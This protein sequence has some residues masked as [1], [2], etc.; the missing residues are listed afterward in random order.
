MV[1][2]EEFW[3][4]CEREGVEWCSFESGE[5]IRSAKNYILLRQ[6]L[7]DD[8]H[9]TKFTRLPPEEVMKLAFQGKYES[10]FNCIVARVA[11]YLKNNVRLSKNDIGD[12]ARNCLPQKF[13]GPAPTGKFNLILADPPWQYR[14]GTTTPNRK[15]EQ[16]YTTMSLDEIKGEL[17][18][19]REEEEK[20][21]ISDDS[22]LFLWAT[23][24]LLPEALEVLNAWGFEYKGNFVW[25]KER[26]GLGH[27]MR[28]QHEHMLV[29]TKGK[30]STPDDA[31]LP[32]SIIREVR[33][34]HSKKPEAAYKI[35]EDMYPTASRLEL[36]GRV[37]RD[38]WTVWGNEI[39]KINERK[40]MWASLDNGSE[41]N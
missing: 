17:R 22:I 41:S 38:G 15:I 6:I 36:F 26:I 31:V 37:E 9:I 8:Y 25:D 7:R 39:D 29:G 18:R 16:Q 20:L 24:P 23:S 11:E 5:Q 14:T 19:L 32:S 28:V 2:C 30:M 35:I 27:W 4:K 34:R 12:I 1:H 13:S 33:T 40:E 21:E 3:E 10:A